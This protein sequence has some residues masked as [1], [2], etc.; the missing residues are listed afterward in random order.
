M[1]KKVLL[2]LIRCYQV[3]ISPLLGSHC[4]FLPTCSVYTYEAITKHGALKGIFL[5]V[6]RILKC[7][8]FHPGGHDPVPEKPG[9]TRKRIKKTRKETLKVR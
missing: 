6:K 1:I 8:P 5:G 9:K 2:F 4:R 7:H 3:G